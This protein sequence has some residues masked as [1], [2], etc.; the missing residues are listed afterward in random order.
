MNKKI[1]FLLFTCAFIVLTYQL[2]YDVCKY[3]AII[4]G[5]NCNQYPLTYEYYLYGLIAFFPALFV[6]NVLPDLSL[7]YLEI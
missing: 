6:P 2:A 4:P 5:F 3:F 7:I 1:I